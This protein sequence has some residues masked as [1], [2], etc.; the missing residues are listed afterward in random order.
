APTATSASATVLAGIVRISASR[1]HTA[2]KAI[3]PRQCEQWT[4]G[5]SVFGG[6]QSGDLES[7]IILARHRLDLLH[8]SGGAAHVRHDDTRLPRAVRPAVPGFAPPRKKGAPANFVDVRK[9]LLFG[10][11][12]GFDGRAAIASHGDNAV[13]NPVDVLFDRRDHVGKNRRA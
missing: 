3:A 1:K 2:R 6:D 5:K 11:S 13:D 4:G 8:V 12:R 7:R 9:P 10:F